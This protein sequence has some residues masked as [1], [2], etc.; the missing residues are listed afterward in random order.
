M[1][2]TQPDST[3][4][5]DLMGPD[6]SVQVPDI[7]SGLDDYLG[8]SEMLVESGMSTPNDPIDEADDDATTEDDDLG[9]VDE[10]G[11]EEDNA[12]GDDTADDD[13]S[14]D[15]DP[16]DLPEDEDDPEGEDENEDQDAEDIDWEFK[17]PVKI[18]GEESEV[19]LEEL[20]KGYQTSQHLSKK[21]RELADE[22]KKFE[23]E[24]TEEMDKV[25]ETAKVLQAQ[26]QYEENQF[27]EEYKDLQEKYKSAKDNG[28]KYE[29]SELKEQME[30]IQQNYW[31]ARK[32]REKL[33]EAIETQEAQEAEKLMNERLETFNEEILDYVDDFSADKAV[34]LREFA[35]SKGISEEVLNSLADA[36]I[37]GA[38]NEF[39][40][41]EKK[42]TTGT[43]K[44]KATTKRRPTSTKKT[45]PTSE[46]KKAA[47]K[48]RSERI[49]SGKFDGGDMEDA[50]DALAGRYFE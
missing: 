37:I 18:D 17:V 46:K 5:A 44:R 10:S 21:G 29:A 14:S 50:L 27:A 47:S 49:S 32:T 41:L 7:E 45:R 30:D 16:D 6:D 43:A 26:S 8:S 23:A 35:I 39:M 42:L 3:L 20:V 24:R 11:D 2:T 12:D 34:E 4:P 15:D 9:D 48:A 22:R 31:K 38:I 40:E 33:A 1:N 13:A 36:K 25:K 28:D 19:D